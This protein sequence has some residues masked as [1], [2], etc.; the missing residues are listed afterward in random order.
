MEARNLETLAETALH[1]TL[2]IKSAEDGECRELAG[3][4]ESGAG[5]LRQGRLLCGACRGQGW[6]RGSYARARS[7][8]QAHPHAPTQEP[9]PLSMARALTQQS[10]ARA[11]I[12]D[13]IRCSRRR[14]CTAVLP[15]WRG[16]DTRAHGAQIGRIQLVKRS[17]TAFTPGLTVRTRPILLVAVLA[18]GP[19]TAAA[20]AFRAPRR[21]SRRAPGCRQICRSRTSSTRR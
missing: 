21:S 18:P 17:K 19:V 6:R 11:Q 20:A 9:A 13:T 14:R 5:V 2:K 15:L 8:P 10:H 7:R 3:P 1:A 12:A 16:A 4:R